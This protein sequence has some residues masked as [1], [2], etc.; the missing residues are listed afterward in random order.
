MV[1]EEHVLDALQT[2]VS[3]VDSLRAIELGNNVKTYVSVFFFGQGP[4]RMPTSPLEQS[5]GMEYDRTKDVILLTFRCDRSISF[6][7][8]NA[9]STRVDHKFDHLFGRSQVLQ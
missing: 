7:S 4:R 5:P 3:D 2:R 9:N 8:V 6:N 1:V